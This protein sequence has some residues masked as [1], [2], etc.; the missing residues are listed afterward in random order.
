[1]LISKD[2]SYIKVFIQQAE[3][4][5]SK[6]DYW[7]QFYLFKS[8]AYLHKYKAA[9]S[10]IKNIEIKSQ[11]ETFNY[12]TYLSHK[13]IGD[14]YLIK[15]EYEKADSQY[16]Q[17]LDIMTQSRYSDSTTLIFL[18]YQLGNVKRQKSEYELASNYLRYALDLESRHCMLHIRSK[19]QTDLAIVLSAQEYYTEANDFIDSSLVNANRIRDTS[20]I[21]RS[22]FVKA[23]FNSFSGKYKTAKEFFDEELKLPK[24][25]YNNSEVYIRII[26]NAIS[27]KDI[28]TCKYFYAQVFKSFDKF[29]K[30][31]KAYLKSIES[32]YFFLI[33]NY[34]KALKSIQEAILFSDNRMN[35]KTI[36]DAPKIKIYRMVDMS[37]YYLGLK[38][39]LLT[40]IYQNTL[41]IK[42]LDKSIEMYTYI[43]SLFIANC[44]FPDDGDELH[45]MDIMNQ[46]YFEAQKA[47]S[48]I[49]ENTH[50][51]KYLELSNTFSERIR[52][53]RFY[54]NLTAKNI[55]SSITN[56]ELKKLLL[57]EDSLSRRIERI[58]SEGNSYSI[59]EVIDERV[60]INAQL[61]SQFPEQYNNLFNIE[62]S[63]IS[64][65]VAW[66]KKENFTILQFLK[67]ED[68]DL[69][70]LK[71][72]S[73]GYKIKYFDRT[74]NNNSLLFQFLRNPSADSIKQKLKLNYLDSSDY[75]KNF[76]L[77]PDAAMSNLPL[78]ML[79][80]IPGNNGTNISDNLVLYSFLL[81]KLIKNDMKLVT[82]K[83]YTS[84]LSVANADKGD[85]DLPYSYLE[86]KYLE[87]INWKE[88]KALRGKQATFNLFANDINNYEIIHLALHGKSS[89]SISNYTGLF[90]KDRF[91]S[92]KEILALNLS[93]PPYCVILNS[94]E[95]QNGKSNLGEGVDNIS[96]A[97]VTNG[98]KIICTYN[99]KVN[100]K[101]SYLIVKKLITSNHI[102]LTCNFDNL[103]IYLN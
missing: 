36:L 76:I 30:E 17:A 96:K 4:L 29:G 19:I 54:R 7:N 1:L 57:K 39:K 31:K 86:S 8:Y 62:I 65:I 2:D 22:L 49:Y 79:F 50:E 74:H 18:F 94:C 92:N 63:N 72:N 41:K 84:I 34:P 37:L 69:A 21:A 51:Y 91:I 98:S 71:Y 35:T 24:K 82:N 68:G 26:Q 67:G 43:D 9:E 102:N 81:C 16:N 83:V 80:I 42:Y 38:A 103:F 89:T 12:I 3:P 14:Y 15:E 48:I 45:A 20:Q 77:I 101:K 97:F 61:E 28:K 53:K 33:K 11:V 52:A 55:L 10:L 66:C 90:F 59:Q 60:N 13:T 47:L 70:I 44:R 56:N 64:Q 23:I 88:F 27:A 95:S 78:H 93:A 46:V 40:D 6:T 32:K 58:N 25:Y 100:D 85:A 75:Y 87:Q 5:A 73:L 99:S